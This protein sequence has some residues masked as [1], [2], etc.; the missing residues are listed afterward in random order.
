[1]SLSEHCRL[2]PDHF[3][4]GTLRVSAG[5]RLSTRSVESTHATARKR[6]RCLSGGTGPTPNAATSH[7]MSR[8]SISASCPMVSSSK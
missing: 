8:F 4:G 1:M 6:E 5:L 2:V 3:K 7:S